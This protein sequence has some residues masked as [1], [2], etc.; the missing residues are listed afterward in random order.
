MFGIAHLGVFEKG[1][2]C[3][4]RERADNKVAQVKLELAFPQ[5]SLN[6]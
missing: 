5:R 3:P 2:G 4:I 6:L 1:K